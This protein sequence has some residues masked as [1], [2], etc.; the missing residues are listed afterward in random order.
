MAGLVGPEH[1]TGL[2]SGSSARRNLATNTC[3]CF[4]QKPHY[5]VTYSMSSEDAQSNCRGVRKNGHH[6]ELKKCGRNATP[7]T[8]SCLSEDQTGLGLSRAHLRENQKACAAQSFSRGFRKK[9]I[10]AL[11]ASWSLLV[12]SQIGS[13]GQ[14]AL[15]LVK[16]PPETLMG[17]HIVIKKL[18]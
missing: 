12:R 18:W 2:C 9:R 11:D 4:I 3:S 14:T 17:G 7:S 15:F 1:I 5:L 16:E 8:P 13:T 6:C 10:I